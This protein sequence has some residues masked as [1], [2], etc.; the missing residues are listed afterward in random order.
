MPKLGGNNA[1]GNMTKQKIISLQCLCD[2]YIWQIWQFSREH[3]KNILPFTCKSVIPK[4]KLRCNGTYPQTVWKNSSLY[5]PTR[6]EQAVSHAFSRIRFAGGYAALPVENA[7]TQLIIW[8]MT[9][10]LL[11]ITVSILMPSPSQRCSFL[12]AKR[13]N[14]VAHPDDNSTNS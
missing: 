14:H 10:M 1:Y 13:V 7:E 8:R 11:T 9:L 12:T 4:G 5:E 3:L 2:A 6:I